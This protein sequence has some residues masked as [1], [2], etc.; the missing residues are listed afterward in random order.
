MLVK[1]FSLAVVI[2]YF[3]T[4]VIEAQSPAGNCPDGTIEDLNNHKCFKFISNRKTFSDA[5]DSC[6]SM[7]GHLAVVDT[8][9]TNNFLAGRFEYEAINLIVVQG[10]LEI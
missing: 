9:F 8:M 7:G 2:L 10:M 3:S 1:C 6:Y 5:E 4:T